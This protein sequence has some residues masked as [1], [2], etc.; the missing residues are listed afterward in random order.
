VDSTIGEACRIGMSLIEQSTL[1]AGVDVGSFNHLRPGAYLSSG[2]HLGNFAEVKASRLGPRVAMGHFS[3]VGDATVGA[4]T[5]IGAG[6]ITVNFGR[7]AHEKGRTTI[8]EGVFIGS[9]TLLVAPLTVGEGAQTGAGSVVTKDVAPYTL[10]VG[11][12]ARAIRKLT[13]PDAGPAAPS[14]QDGDPAGDDP[15]S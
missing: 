13:P 8:G 9:D 2:V 7:G 3:Y 5:N 12:P 4:N 11:L 1:E 15:A 6:T 10:V 14:P